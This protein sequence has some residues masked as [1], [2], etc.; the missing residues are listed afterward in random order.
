GVSPPTRASTAQIDGPPTGAWTR[1]FNTMSE[2]KV[3][4]PLAMLPD[5]RALAAGGLRIQDNSV[6]SADLY[7]PRTDRWTPAGSLLKS[8]AGHWAVA[9]PDGRVLAGGGL[10]YD[11]DTFPE[12]ALT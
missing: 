2:P 7:D 10:N 8:R 12:H 3:D 4:P 9:L 6:A 1:T 11:P 5:G